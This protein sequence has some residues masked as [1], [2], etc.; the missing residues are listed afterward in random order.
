MADSSSLAAA[1][2]TFSILSF[3]LLAVALVFFLFPDFSKTIRAGLSRTGSVDGAGSTLGMMGAFLG[4]FSPDIAL[5]SGF[6]SDIMNGTFR[7]S[8]TSIIGVISVILHW[9]I[10]G[11][12][13]GFGS[14]TA[15]VTDAAAAVASTVA[16][17]TSAAQVLGVGSEPTNPTPPPASSG[18]GPSRQSRSRWRHGGPRSVSTMSSMPTPAI[19]PQSI[20]R[21]AV[22]TPRQEPSSPQETNSSQ[23]TSIYGPTGTR[24]TRSTQGQRR[25]PRFGQ[26]GGRADEEE[27]V[28]TGG[29]RWE[30]PEDIRSK[31]NPCSIRGLGMF[32]ISKSPMG[33]AALSSVFSVYFLDMTVNSKRPTGDIMLYLFFS[34]A[35][36]GLNLFAY[37]KFKCYGDSFGAIAK[38]TILPMIIGLAAGSSG[39]AVLQTTFPSYLPLDPKAQGSPAMPGKYAKCS[40]PNDK[41]EFVCDAYKDGKR[42][43]STVI[44]D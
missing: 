24:M 40:A 7:Y 15:A 25:R 17:S 26:D 28:Q 13:H 42:I 32:D 33:I 11:L 5:L 39:F 31:F 16:A 6:V 21:S 10:A 9:I 43:S 12:V 19:G 37:S 35:I 27:D 4:A 14:T 8:V 20:L 1:S 3:V 44:E 23:E 34:G 36:Y 41:D 38:S 22:I 29:Q 30:I 2:L 18:Q